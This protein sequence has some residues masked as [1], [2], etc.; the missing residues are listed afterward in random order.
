MSEHHSFVIFIQCGF[1]FIHIYQHNCWL[2]GCTKIT[3][4]IWAVSTPQLG[5]VNVHTAILCSC[6]QKAWCVIPWTV[7]DHGGKSVSSAWEMS[8]DWDSKT[9]SSHG[10]R[11]QNSL[12]VQKAFKNSLHGSEWGK[13]KGKSLLAKLKFSLSSFWFN[14]SLV[15]FIVVGRL[16]S[17]ALTEEWPISYH[18]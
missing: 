18:F 4:I 15:I 12:L 3:E 2:L 11:K 1:F 6:T 8:W 17:C 5:T 16:C 13:P 10:K 7:Y 9:F 14:S